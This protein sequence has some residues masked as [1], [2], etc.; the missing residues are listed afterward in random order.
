[1][2]VANH[3]RG[4]Q[5]FAGSS[6]ALGADWEAM[7]SNMIA[8]YGALPLVG[9]PEQIVDGLLA[10]SKAGLD[11]TTL[12]WVD[13]EAGIAQFKER[14]LPLMVQAGLREG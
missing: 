7:A 10:F 11:G 9:T 8:G 4:L 14:I 12:S 5:G 3:Y 13:Y 2:S 1:M 6:C